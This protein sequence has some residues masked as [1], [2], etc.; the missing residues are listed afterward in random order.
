MLL[1]VLAAGALGR[2]LYPTSAPLR[3]GTLAVGGGT[4]GHAHLL[5]Y[6]EHG[7]SD[8]APALFLHGGPVRALIWV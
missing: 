6:E 5:H 3:T 8:G 1:P 4:V 2:P 7:R